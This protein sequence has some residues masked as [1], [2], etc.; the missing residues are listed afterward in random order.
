MNLDLVDRY[1][2]LAPRIRVVIGIIMVV[3]IMP[4]R[5]VE[6]PSGAQTSERTKWLIMGSQNALRRT[7]GQPTLVKK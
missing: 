4:A 2:P 5:G 7:L 1:Q 6:A 3:N